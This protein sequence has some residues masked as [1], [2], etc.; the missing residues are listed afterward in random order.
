MRDG[1]LELLTPELILTV[2]FCVVFLNSF[3]STLNKRHFSS[4]YYIRKWRLTRYQTTCLQSSH[5]LEG[6]PRLPSEA[7]IHPQNA[8]SGYELYAPHL[9]ASSLRTVVFLM[10]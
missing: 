2:L 9:P 5:E 7:H 6:E 8:L 1:E 10:L 3:I 4:F